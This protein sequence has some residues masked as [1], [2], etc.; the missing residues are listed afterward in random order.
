MTIELYRQAIGFKIIVDDFTEGEVTLSGLYGHTY[1]IKPSSSSSTNI[2]QV[3]IEPEALPTAYG[4]SNVSTVGFLSYVKI[5]Y[6]DGENQI[7]LLIRQL[8][9]IERN[10]L[11]TLRFSLSDAIANGGITANVIE[12]GEMKEV[13]MEF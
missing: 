7:Q 10:T 8:F 4:S 2:L 1:S 9:P 12:E 13:Q 11:Y 5:F 6:Y 3:A